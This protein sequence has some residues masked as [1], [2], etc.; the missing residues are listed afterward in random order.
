MYVCM[1]ICICISGRCGI[2]HACTQVCIYV[3]IHVYVYMLCY[4]ECGPYNKVNRIPCVSLTVYMCVSLKQESVCVS[5]CVYVC[6]NT[7]N[8]GHDFNMCLSACMHIRMCSYA[9]AVLTDTYICTTCTHASRGCT[10]THTRT[11]KL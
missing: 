8:R 3:C 4:V 10:H 1:Y 5:H 2:S 7:K 9:I 11:C 6:E